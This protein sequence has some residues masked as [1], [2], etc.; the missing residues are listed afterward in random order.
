MGWSLLTFLEAVQTGLGSFSLGYAKVLWPL[1]RAHLLL[2]KAG[3]WLTSV[4]ENTDHGSRR[5]TLR[6]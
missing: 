3:S 2:G 6:G 4:Q 5:E 1:S